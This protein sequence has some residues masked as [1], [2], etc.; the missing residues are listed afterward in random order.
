M[1][2]AMW[3]VA[4][5]GIGWIGYALLKANRKRGLFD[6]IVIGSAG[7]FFGGYLLAPLLGG[8]EIPGVLSP[9]ALVVAL[10]SATA[11][12]IIGNLLSKRYG[13]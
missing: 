7:G 12:L 4:G 5:A 8:V 9:F 2:M 3:I 10:A 1:N 6:S 11:C 13:V